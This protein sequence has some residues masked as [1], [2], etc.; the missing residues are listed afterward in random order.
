VLPNLFYSEY[1]CHHKP[2]GLVPRGG[3]FIF[4]FSDPICGGDAGRFPHFPLFRP[5]LRRRRGAVFSFSAFPT[6][7]PAAARGGFF[8]FRFSD[9]TSGGGAGQLREQCCDE[10]AASQNAPGGV[11]GNSDCKMPGLCARRCSALRA[12]PS[13]TVK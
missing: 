3:F 12:T 11:Q 6:Q 5:N 8:I 2:P 10:A 1:F 7:L 4:R 9:P 13:N